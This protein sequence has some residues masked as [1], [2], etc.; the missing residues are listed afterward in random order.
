MEGAPDHFDL[1]TRDIL[2]VI[3][4]AVDRDAPYQARNLLGHARALFNWAIEAGDYGI[5]VSP[6]DR[7]R[8]K[9]LIGERVP[10]DR[11][12]TDAE[13]RAVWNSAERMGYPFGSIIQLLM[14]T[15]VRKSEASGARWRE[16]DMLGKVWTVPAERFKSKSTHL[17]PLTKDAIS[18]LRA[19][20]LFNKGD[21]LF[22]TSFGQRP[23]TAFAKAKLRLDRLME[24]DLGHKPEPFRLH[25][26]RRT[27]RLTCRAAYRGRSRGDDHRARQEGHSA[28]LRPA[29][30]RR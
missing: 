16:M 26:I 3:N 23:V 14:L 7:I 1:A 9:H 18:L 21:H 25:D 13:I 2:D 17:V 6:C 11:V 4:E 19:L 8:P 29:P 27:V 5:E 30:I 15:G 24:E 10:R 28:R 22:S 12:L 20:P